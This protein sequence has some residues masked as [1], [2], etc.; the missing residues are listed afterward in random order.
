MDNTGGEYT[1]SVTVRPGGPH[2]YGDI[3]RQLF[4]AGAILIVVGAPFY[5]DSLSAE[6]LYE[7]LAA[8][9]LAG[10]AALVNPHNKP[11]LLANAIAAGVGLVVYAFWGLSEY[12]TSTWVQFILRELIAIIFLVAFYFSMKTVRAFILHQIG[13][14]ENVAE[15]DE[16]AALAEDEPT[17]F[18]RRTV[19][20]STP[21]NLFGA[22]TF[23]RQK[24]RSGAG[25]EGKDDASDANEGYAKSDIAEEEEEDE[26]DEESE[27]AGKNLSG[28]Y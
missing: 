18:S 15:F 19:S 26:D 1:R 22:F 10:L 5:A 14:R 23:G 4:I 11:L 28:G 24:D 17:L 8:L 3:V 7:I 27:V 9:I 12:S 25:S 6:L 13:K 20:A 16:D 21:F 2:Y